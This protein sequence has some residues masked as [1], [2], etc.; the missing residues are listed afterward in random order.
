MAT[1]NFRNIEEYI[2]SQP[3]TTQLVL[4]RVRSAIRAALP[5]AD[6]VISYKMPAYK[7]DGEVVLYFASWKQHY[8]LYPAGE[9]LAGV[10]KDKLA[11]YKINKGTIRFA[12]SEPVPVKLIGRIARLRAKEVAQRRHVNASTSRNWR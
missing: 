4:E 9:H 8:S 6:E 12:L 3:E 1:T 10:L 7:L 2:A 11:P 5:E